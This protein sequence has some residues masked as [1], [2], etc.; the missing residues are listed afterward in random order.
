VIPDNSSVYAINCGIKKLPCRS[1]SAILKEA[2]EHSKVLAMPGVYS[3]KEVL[4]MK[5]CIV[6]LSE[7]CLCA[8]SFPS[9]HVLDRLHTHIGVDMHACSQM[10]NTGLDFTGKTVSVLST[11]GYNDTV[12]DCGGT[13]GPVAIF[14]PTGRAQVPGCVCCVSFHMH[15]REGVECVDARRCGYVCVL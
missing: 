13:Y 10:Q 12:I 3:G 11:H 8:K 9:R 2:T 6:H 5:L 15:A 1:F 4:L 7:D 14:S